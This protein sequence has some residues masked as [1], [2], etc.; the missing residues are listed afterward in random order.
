MDEVE[1]ILRPQLG[2]HKWLPAGDK[3]ATVREWG[4]LR[5]PRLAAGAH[6]TCP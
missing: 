2:Q 5:A 6:R 4:V 3:G 1:A